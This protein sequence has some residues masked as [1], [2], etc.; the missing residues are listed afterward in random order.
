[1]VRW[2]PGPPIFVSQTYIRTRDEPARLACEG[3]FPARPSDWSAT[4]CL[5]TP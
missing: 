1:M 4:G 3:Q 2:D 5:S